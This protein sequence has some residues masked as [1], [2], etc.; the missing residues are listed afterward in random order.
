M[1]SFVA[2]LILLLLPTLVSANGYIDN[3]FRNTN[4]DVSFSFHE[5]GLAVK[6]SNDNLL[7][8]LAGGMLPSFLVNFETQ[9]RYFGHS[10]AGWNLTA[11]LSTYC[12]NTQKLGDDKVV[13]L[14]TSAS[15]LSAYVTPTLFYT[16][17]DKVFQENN[18]SAFRAGLG[19]GAGYLSEQAA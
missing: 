17:G 15:G 6:D 2:T 7:G 18:Y 14:N 4:I 9:G 11:N 8:K 13:N 1:R 16:M 5:L 3:Y 12:V 19:L 10:N